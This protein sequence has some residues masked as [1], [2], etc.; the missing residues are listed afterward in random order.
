V[1]ILKAK[2]A[3]RH[4]NKEMTTLIAMLPLFCSTPVCSACKVPHIILIIRV[5]RLHYALWQILSALK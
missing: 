4:I 5:Q 3:Q 1:V 2:V